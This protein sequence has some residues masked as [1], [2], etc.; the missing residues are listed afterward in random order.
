LKGLELERHREARGG[1]YQELAKGFGV[2]EYTSMYERSQPNAVRFKTAS[3]FKRQQLGDDS[4]AGSFGSSLLRHVLYAI[5]E[6]VREENVRV[7]LDYLKTDGAIDYWGKR[8]AILAMLAYLKPLAHVAHM[9]HW[10]ADA[11]AAERLA[12]VVENDH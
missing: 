3:E 10:Q 2:R 4:A 11:D 1:A 9:P 5:H 12:G 7:G 6:T 8:K